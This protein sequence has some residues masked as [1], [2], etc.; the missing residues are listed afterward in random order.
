M[1]G[2]GMVWVP[3]LQKPLASRIRR[4]GGGYRGKN[5]SHQVTLNVFHLDASLVPTGLFS[6]LH[7]F[8]SSTL[9]E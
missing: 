6:R 1:S 3:P 7:P 5:F 9:T 2:P 8:N 4:I